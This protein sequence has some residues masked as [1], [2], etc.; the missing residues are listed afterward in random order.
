[1]FRSFEQA[2]G[3]NPSKYQGTGL[4]LSISSSLIQMMGSSIRLDSE[5]GK[6]SRFSFSIWLDHGEDTEKKEMQ[7]EISFEGYHILVVE[8]N[9]INS[10]IAR[11]LLE[12]RGFQV[13]PRQ[14]SGS[15]IPR[16]APMT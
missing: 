4:G 16:P 13:E 2:S 7:D 3:R 15:A 1:M 10:E 5:P 9:E 8:D 12:E 6:G 14:W 11:C